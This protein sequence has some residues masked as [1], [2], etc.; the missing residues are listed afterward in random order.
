MSSDCHWQLDKSLDIMTQLYI[1][2]IVARNSNV[3]YSQEYLDVEVGRE[4]MLGIPHFEAAVKM[5]NGN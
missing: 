1:I 3:N 2:I 5:G 4:W